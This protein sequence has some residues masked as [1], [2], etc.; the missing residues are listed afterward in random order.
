VNY[1]LTYIKVSSGKRVLA[2][3][4]GFVF[5]GLVGFGCGLV[6]GGWVFAREKVL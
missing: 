3:V 6:C 4:V 1:Q 2:G 5:C